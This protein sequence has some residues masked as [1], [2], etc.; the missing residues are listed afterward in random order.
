MKRLL[1]LVAMGIATL[2]HAQIADSLQRKVV[3]QGVV[4][5]RDLGGYSTK[6][7]K[8]V[9]WGQVYRSAD[10]SRLTDQDVQTLQALKLALVCD[11]RGPS[12]IKTNPD[13][14]PAGAEYL[15]LPAGS[16][17]L[18]SSMNYAKLNTDSLILS[19]YSTTSFLKAKYKPMFDQMLTLPEGKS[20]MFHCTAGKDRTGIG[21]ALFLS[22][23]GVEREI[24]IADYEATNYYWKSTQEKMAAM[25]VK[26]GMPETKVK[27]MLGAKRLYIETFFHTLEK[28]YGGMD[29]FFAQELGL[30][31]SQ[32]A[33]LR[34]RYLIN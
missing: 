21:A 16:E 32:I 34:S 12:E 29:Q 31:V 9:K 33:A 27:A 25:M 20:M 23:L 24:I 19:I 6:D 7:G 2:S 22:A 17:T 28:Q 14:L 8:K 15:N 13:R 3:L 11:F 18:P 5:F 10:I 30:G 1:F 4:N 26:S